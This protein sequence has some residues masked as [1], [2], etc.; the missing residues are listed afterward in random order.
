M[1]RT[2]E[3]RTI[4]KNEEN[5]SVYYSY[6]NEEDSINKLENKLSEISD[7]RISYYVEETKAELSIAL[8]KELTRTITNGKLIR[9]VL[10]KNDFEA[11]LVISADNRYV[12]YDCLDQ[13]KK[14]L[15]DEINLL[16]IVEKEL[17]NIT[18][19]AYLDFGVPDTQYGE[20][21]EKE[22]V[23]RLNGEDFESSCYD[24]EDIIKGIIAS[25]LKYKSNNTNVVFHD[26]INS[27]NKYGYYNYES[28]SL[29]I[30]DSKEND[31]KFVA[32]INCVDL[33]DNNSCFIKYVAPKYP[34]TINII[35]QGDNI[36]ELI[37]ASRSGVIAKKVLQQFAEFFIR[38]TEFAKNNT[39]DSEK[40]NNIVTDDITFEFESNWN[41][42]SET[43]NPIERFRNIVR[44]NESQIAIVYDQKQL[45]YKEVDEQSDI[46]A[47]KLISI[48]VKKE[49]YVIVSIPHDERLVVLL[50][51][52]LKANG[53]YVPVD[54][55]Y[56]EE[57]LLFIA[58]DSKAKFI[59][60]DKEF[61][62]NLGTKIIGYNDLS[63]MKDVDTIAL[64]DAPADNGYVIY[65]SG[66][67]GNPKGVIV[68][69]KN[70]MSLIEATE[71]LYS[72]GKNDVWTMFHS[73]S[74]DFSVWEMWG[75]LLT[76]GKLIVVPRDV[77]KS[78]YDFI[79]LLEKNKVTI[80]S[81]TPASFYAVVKV[82]LEEKY[83]KLKAVRLVVFGGE[84]LDTSELK[85]WFQRYPTAKCK[86]A[87]MYG[88]TE[89]TV[90]STYRYVH[91]REE[92][93][94]SRSIGK[95]LDGWEISIRNKNGHRTLI[96]EP[97]EIWV[98]GEGVAIGYVNREELTKQKFV[99]ADNGKR[100]Y[101]SGDLGRYR[102]DGNIDYLGR[103]DSQVK[104]RGYRIELDE[105]RNVLQSVSYINEAVVNVINGDDITHKQ[106]VAYVKANGV[107]TYTET[108]A[109][110]R[111]KLPEYMIPSKIIFVDTI[112]M[113]I[114]GKV[115]YKYLESHIN[116]NKKIIKED[117]SSQDTIKQIWEKILGVALSDDDDFFTVGGNSILAVELVSEMKRNIA[118]TLKLRDLYLNSTLRKMKR[119]L[120]EKG[121]AC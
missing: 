37:L 92:N 85:M 4:R 105:I 59:I 67:T 118:G 45:T 39:I 31:T 17:E 57:R 109:Y 20:L 9:L 30:T 44:N 25:L 1:N 93:V 27:S 84:A 110:L 40:V 28:N 62:I 113:T 3:E 63:N 50:V 42:S 12:E 11:V 101:R 5:T 103:I 22:Y 19:D 16:N 38:S 51:A 79:N 117:I 43:I 56:P 104:I 6:I 36:S 41:I 88:I 34:L 91:C 8:A 49:D 97:G 114:N 32:F 60:S 2:V 87:N 107:H 47:R 112:P 89:T 18:Q 72:L 116:E 53:F 83:S 66:T 75:C 54:P 95:P 10:I 98:A 21:Y 80:L 100:Y 26:S 96:G 111:K 90:H 70:I 33:N 69:A 74:F 76:G 68:P 7:D 58:E 102:A 48:G 94:M 14:Y 121:I 13:I 64:D 65:T 52:I 106:I 15:F 24:D 73:Y 77:T 120:D 115:D 55:N 86:L 82:D 119:F 71:E 23:I 108:V 61:D 78:H 99:I 29:L 35:K 46:I 81:Q